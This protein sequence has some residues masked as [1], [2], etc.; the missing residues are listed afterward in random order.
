MKRIILSVLLVV[1]VF[2]SLGVVLGECTDSDETWDETTQT[3]LEP[4]GPGPTSCNEPDETWDETTQTC[5]EPT[6]ECDANIPC[7]D[8]LECYSF[9]E[10]GL[11]C[12]EPN[13][14]SYYQCPENTECT[15]AEIYPP[16]IICSGTCEGDECET[17]VSY[18][19][20]TKKEYK[21]RHRD[22]E[23]TV[24]VSEA[25]NKGSQGVLFET[26]GFSVPSS[27]EL[28]V[29]NEKVFMKTSNGRKAE[30]KIM[31]E[32]AS[33]KAIE[34]LGELDFNVEL[35]EIGKGEEVKPVYELEGKKQGRFL[36]LF[37]IKGEVSAQVSAETGEVV[38]VGKPWWSFLASGI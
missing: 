9:P 14:C 8:G 11:K 18:D 29:E 37:K 28:S 4:T 27:R 30:I 16:L 19:I 26:G 3:C 31:P 10:E 24:S 5:L 38:K 7:S 33:E 15:T 22:R 6:S 34:R 35:K 21:I 25:A 23:R 1:L 2:G 32:T 13:P 20:S 17:A 12:A 36:G